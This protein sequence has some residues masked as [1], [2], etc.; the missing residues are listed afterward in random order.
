M[1]VGH[2]FL[3]FALCAGFALWDRWSRRSA[4]QVG[5]VAAA[6]ALLPDVD[7]AYALI[8]VVGLV[9]GT[10]DGPLAVARGFWGASTAVHRA[11]THSVLLAVPAA[12]AFALWAMPGAES[13]RDRLFRRWVGLVLLAGLCLIAF[14]VSGLLGLAAMG[15]YA[16]IG[17]SFA[18][19]IARFGTLDSRIIL[20]AIFVGLISHPFGDVFTGTPPNFLYPFP[21]V[22]VGD[23]FHLHPDP[24]LHL[25]YT[26]GLELAT[27][28]VAFRVFVGTI[29]GF[30]VGTVGVGYAVTGLGFALLVPIVQAPT[31]EASY[32]FVLPVVGFGVLVG[33]VAYWA[34]VADRHPSGIDRALATAAVALRGMLVAFGSYAIVYLLVHPHLIRAL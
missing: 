30:S 31:L 24:T 29:D 9:G 12:I 23:V 34:S 25:L 2:A 28:W 32:H 14:Q 26:F 22:V 18:T 11:V 1:I 21:V 17:L 3:A 4:R 8:G 27:I 33:V 13:D 5:L 6:F 15:L 16:A 7:M 10:P 20:A 19:A